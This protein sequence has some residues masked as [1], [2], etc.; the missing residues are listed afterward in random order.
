LVQS[1]IKLEVKFRKKVS[2]AA[3]LSCFVLK[4]RDF[5]KLRGVKNTQKEAFDITRSFKRIELLF[6]S[7]YLISCCA[8]V[9]ESNGSS[10]CSLSEKLSSI[11][12]V[13][14]CACGFKMFGISFSYSLRKREVFF[15][16][17]SSRFSI[18]S[19]KIA[20]I[21]SLSDFLFGYSVGAI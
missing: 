6:I 16:D 12:W 4:S 13:N 1:F 20:I 21:L 3:H 5:S 9:I 2:S 11:F 14:L 7:H 8:M 18:L 17:S 10:N 15:F 19:M